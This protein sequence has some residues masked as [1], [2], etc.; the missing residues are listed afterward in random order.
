MGAYLLTYSRTVTV[1]T[2]GSADVKPTAAPLVPAQS[3]SRSAR[4]QSCQNAGTLRTVQLVDPVRGK[5]QHDHQVAELRHGAGDPID[6][7]E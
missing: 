2:P 4:A 6:S 3:P 5:V 1:M 7:C